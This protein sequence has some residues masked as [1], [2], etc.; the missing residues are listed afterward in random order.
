MIKEEVCRKIAEASL[1]SAG[2]GIPWRK[3]MQKKSLRIGFIGGSVTMGFVKDHVLE[4]AYP[5][6]LCES[7]REQG[8]EAKAIVCAEPGMNAMHGNLL[9]EEWLLSQM[10]DIV[11][12][13]FAINETTLRPSVIAFES[14]LRKIM[15]HENAPVVCL[16]ILRNVNDYHCESYMLPIAEHYGLPCVR[17][18]PGLNAAIEDGA[19]QWP[20]YADEE[21]HPNPEGHRLLADCLLRLMDTAKALPETEALPLPEPWL[22]APYANMRCLHPRECKNVR[23]EAEIVKRYSWYFPESW[24]LTPAQADWEITLTGRTLF[25]FYEVHYLP[26]F[27]QAEIFLDGEPLD[28]PVLHGNSMYGWGNTR[29]VTVFEGSECRTH[30][31]RL[32][33]SDG[34]F[35]VAALG[36]CE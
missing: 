15:T 23:T 3:L 32:K 18:R 33:A 16:F 6:M 36:L 26:E 24:R 25:L 14:L 19:L 35:Y 22:E 28:P 29:F 21:S 17:L 4:K 11:F 30:T 8:Y 12:V 2:Q 13:E 20:D 10:P 1:H 9:A 31:V 34:N 7:L 5:E 27:G